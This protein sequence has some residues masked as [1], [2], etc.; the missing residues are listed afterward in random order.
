M[1]HLKFEILYYRSFFPT[2]PRAERIVGHVTRHLTPDTGLQLC[3][4]A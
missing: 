1:K 4:N 2:P 3:Y